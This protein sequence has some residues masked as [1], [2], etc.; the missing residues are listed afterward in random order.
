M[1]WFLLLFFLVTC[2]SQLPAKPT[3]ADRKLLLPEIR[4]KAENG[5]AKAQFNLGNY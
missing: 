4:A 5:D 2:A 1:A 3:E